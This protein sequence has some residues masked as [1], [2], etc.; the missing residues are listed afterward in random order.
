MLTPSPL[1]RL[2][3]RRAR[4]STVGSDRLLYRVRRQFLLLGLLATTIALVDIVRIDT[5]VS[6]PAY[7][8]S[9]AA[10]FV[11]LPVLYLRAE[12]WTWL[13]LIGPV[14]VTTLGAASGEYDWA[15][16]VMYGS[17][18]LHMTF[19]SSWRAA[20][21]TL[22]YIVAYELAVIATEGAET[23]AGGLVS[24]V[25]GVVVVT[26][27][28]RTIAAIVRR[29]EDH[30]R[31]DEALTSAS[32]ALLTATDAQ[33]V[34]RIALD[35]VAKLLPADAAAPEDHRI[36]LWRHRHGVLEMTAIAGTEIATVSLP[37]EALPEDL[38]AAYFSGAVVRLEP[39]RMAALKAA[40]GVV[41]PFTH[42]VSVPLRDG[43]ELAGLLFV[44][45]PSRL[46]DDI[47][48]AFERFMHEVSLADILV[49]RQAL[50]L[51]VVENSADG[52]LLV[53]RGDVIE[54]AS[55]SLTTIAGRPAESL[56]GRPFG[57]LIFR[58]DDGVPVAVRGLDDATGL[59]GA[60]YAG[61]TENPREVELV[62]NTLG[63]DAVVVNVRDV[64]ERRRLEEEVTY[65]AFH[66]PVTG[67]ANR[68]LFSDRLAHALARAERDDSK[69]AVA[70]IDLDEFKAVNDVHGHSAGDQLL[71]ETAQR[72]TRTLRRSDTCARFGGD[73]FAVLMEDVSDEVEVTVVLSRVV[74]A[75]R[76]P[77]LVGEQ[78]VSVSAS[79]GVR[80][81]DT[82]DDADGL[83][84]DADVAM[85]VAKGDGKNKLVRFQD[86]MRMAALDRLRVRSELQTAIEDGQ[87]LM[88]YQPIVDLASGD[89]AA[90]EALVRWEHPTRGLVPPDEF[91]PV[92]E[93]T[94]LILP[95]GRW[96]LRE[97][98]RQL[99]A[100]RREGV[101]GE[102]TRVCVNLSAHQL[103][104]P[105]IFVDV[106]EA[107]DD[108]GL[109]ASQL[110]LEVTETALVGEPERA[111]A[112][113]T[114]LSEMGIEVAID[115]F[116]TGYSS[117]AYLQRFPVQ[118][119]KVDRSFVSR[120]AEGPEQAALAHAIVKLAHA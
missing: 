31:R 99:A 98:C 12:R 13:D 102:G 92:A 79:V 85:Y 70:L 25:I 81:G 103:L 90:F 32:S 55:A 35:G 86:G 21:N 110:C 93:D 29:H 59:S 50:L 28:V 113:L 120:V 83:V 74:E 17:L 63:R 53:G 51:G 43:D 115:D 97:S 106:T 8:V 18:F 20:R 11:W 41:D 6:L 100:W 107:L 14:L 76:R 96:V 78:E 82:R 16:G 52:I 87:L 64:T 84:G 80:I 109:S 58:S 37:L 118:V 46:D 26:Y 44:A 69:V 60:L 66:D 71:V 62:V 72:L 45:T 56:V 116:G 38:Q 36:T 49:R 10:L 117:F 27:L 33:D 5:M 73:E 22:L 75:I 30:R 114:A 95:L 68:A 23:V 7:L 47:V 119:I 61:D 89:V 19:G 4:R 57:E 2:R 108:A 91:I 54:F 104:A 65:R 48:S 9:V 67:L 15:F 40:M 3:A 88:H 42:G 77:F 34:A 24:H 1:A 39:A 101:V 105:T 112:V 94:G 111:G